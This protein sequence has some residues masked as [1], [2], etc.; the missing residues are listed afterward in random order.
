MTSKTTRKRKLE[1]DVETNNNQRKR[2]KLNDDCSSELNIKQMTEQKDTD[3]EKGFVFI[4]AHGAGTN[5]K[6]PNMM[7]WKKRLSDLGVVIMFD[8][9]RPFNKMDKLIAT[10]Q[11]MI[12]STIEQYPTHKLILIGTSMGSRVSI[13]LANT[14]SLPDKCTNIIA[15]GYPLYVKKGNKMRDQ[16]ILDFIHSTDK[17]LKQTRLCLISG[18]KDCMAPQ[19]IMNTFYDK[20]KNEKAGSKLKCELHWIDGGN[21]SLKVGKRHVL[22]QNDVDQTVVG[23][24]SVFIT[25]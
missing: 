14:N 4:L 13:H 15:L 1:S 3:D 6:H 5:S 8:F 20:I 25:K 9:K 24:V 11:A 12:D 2:R 7:N 18:S 17:R 21:H 22:S 23:I 19:K 16:V 10:Y